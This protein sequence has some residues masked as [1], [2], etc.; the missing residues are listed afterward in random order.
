[1][2]KKNSSKSISSN[3][4][5]NHTNS[6]NG[7]QMRNNNNNNNLNMGVSFENKSE[8]GNISIPHIAD[9]YPEGILIMISLE[10]NFRLINELLILHR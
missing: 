1:M 2:T 10:C 8:D 3:K 6:I 9:F 7:A 4:N 5:S